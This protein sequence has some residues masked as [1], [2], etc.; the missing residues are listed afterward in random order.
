MSRQ[1]LGLLQIY[2]GEG[3]GKTTA[4]LGLALRAWG[5]GLQICVVQFMKKG[6]DY[7]E[8]KALRRLGVDVFQFGSGR[9]VRLGKVCEEE[10]ELA[11]RGVDFAVAAIQSGE[12]D[13]VILDEVNVTAFFGLLDPN[14]VLAKV[15]GHEGVEV[16]FTGRRAP[17]EF[18]AAADLV[19]VMDMVKHPYE[20][21]VDARKGVE[22]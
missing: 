16:V 8:I 18:L 3:K 17:P 10:M 6:D 15:D 5:H 12:Y 21:G 13:L 7:G 11:A 14:E 2:T 20:E 1:G 9:F 19:T 22:F 4:S